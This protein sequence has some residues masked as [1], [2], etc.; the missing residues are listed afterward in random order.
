M[1][2]TSGGDLLVNQTSGSNHTIYKATSDTILSVTSNTGA[3]SVYI[4][5]VGSTGANLG[6]AAAIY[7]QKATATNRSINAA[8]TF[9]AS[10]ADY[11]EYMVKAGSFDIAKGDVCG[12]DSD[13][14]LTNVFTDAIGFLVK[15]TNPSYVGGDAWGTEDVVGPKPDA[16][17]TDA[18]VA[19]EAALEVER[20]KVDRIAFAGQVPVN[21]IGAVPGQYIV[22]VDA[23]DGG[24]TG[25]AK[26]EADLTLAEYMRAVG[27]VIAIEDDGRARIIVKVA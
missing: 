6:Q 7:V 27:K 25:I 13:G 21:V 19:W 10:G 24:I 26:D 23:G 2:I 11:A 1:R 14:K 4:N 9:N 5:G 16:D 15:S 12:V 17:D 18:L 3:D 8:G 22:P 20:Q